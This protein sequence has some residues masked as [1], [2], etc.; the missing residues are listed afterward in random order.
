ML[1]AFFSY[2]R[3]ITQN[4]LFWVV[5][6]LAAAA[7]IALLI[8]CEALPLWVYAVMLFVPPT[9]YVA[10]TLVVG[11]IFFAILRPDREEDP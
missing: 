1:L 9:I 10:I 11:G 3:E 7:D 6:T 4:I 2:L 8:V 5:V